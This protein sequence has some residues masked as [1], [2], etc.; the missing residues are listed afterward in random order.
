[1]ADWGDEFSF[2]RVAH[3]KIY[4][5]IDISI[6]IRSMTTK[7]DHSNKTIEADAGDFIL[8]RWRGS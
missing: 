4:E 8:S 3:V 6:S 1:M 5:R 2:V 7:F